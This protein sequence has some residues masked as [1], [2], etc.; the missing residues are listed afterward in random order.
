MW[1][2]PCCSYETEFFPAL[3][4]HVKSKHNEIP[5]PVCG[6]NIRNL[7]KHAK[8][9]NDERHQLLYKCL[10]P[11]PRRKQSKIKYEKK[12]KRSPRKPVPERP[13]SNFAKIYLDMI[14]C[15]NQK[16]L[17]SCEYCSE[18]KNCETV[19]KLIEYLTARKS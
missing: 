12:K 18:V 16:Q 10:W 7:I 5:C 3:A 9:K 17:K 4:K 14:R 11:S 8:Q 6:A 19:K 1:K 13:Q 15:R 2:C